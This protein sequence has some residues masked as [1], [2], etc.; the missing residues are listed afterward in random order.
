MLLHLETIQILLKIEN[1]DVL[2]QQL[3]KTTVNHRLGYT[4][5]KPDI[6][7]GFS[8]INAISDDN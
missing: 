4:I 6:R 2:K 3:V 7:E 5:A 1:I 8:C